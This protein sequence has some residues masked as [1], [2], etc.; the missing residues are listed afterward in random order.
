MGI[1]PREELA[2]ARNVNIPLAISQALVTH[3]GHDQFARI[4]VRVEP[5]RPD[6]RPGLALAH[7]LEPTH[8]LFEYWSDV[9]AGVRDVSFSLRNLAAKVT[10]L[11]ALVHS[12]DSGRRSFR[13]AVMKAVQQAVLECGT[14]EE[15]L[16]EACFPRVQTLSRDGVA[17]LGNG[18]LIAELSRDPCDDR[19][20]W[21]AE[22]RN[23]DPTA[24]EWMEAAMK[25][26]C[27][28][29]PPWADVTLHLGNHLSRGHSLTESALFDA[30]DAALLHGG[31]HERHGHRLELEIFR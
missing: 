15:E 10:V 23:L 24:N 1:L 25:R 9:C 17:A 29:E 5:Y 21:T 8:P 19:L 27:T 3:R 2:V 22:W 20:S 11:D 31:R 4:A 18:Q 28:E 6:G 7:T 14:E 13:S 26:L 16:P 30:I 12:V